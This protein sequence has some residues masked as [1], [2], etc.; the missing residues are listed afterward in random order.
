MKHKP[1]SREEIG[2]IDSGNAEGAGSRL[3][4][5]L[6]EKGTLTEED[7]RRIVQSQREKGL[8]FGEAAVSLGLLTRDDLQRALSEQYSYPYLEVGGSALDRLLVAAHRPFSR[9]A[10]SFRTLRTEL[11]MRWFDDRHKIIAVSMP[12]HGQAASVVAANLAICFAQLGERT[13]LI[14]G[15]FRT[16]RQ[17]DL[18]GLPV[19]PG[20]SGVLTGRSALSDAITTIKPFDNLAVIPAGPI[21]PN[22]QELLGQVS[23]S[24]LLETAPA[25]FNIVVVEMPPILEFADAQRIASLAGGCVIATRRHQTSLA[26]IELCKLQINP[27]GAKIVGTVIIE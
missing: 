4:G 9:Q 19:T 20:L 2:A 27:T 12:R 5:R 3:G 22:P 23:F 15:N 26:D 13:L 16:P 24:Y 6:V 7:V 8:L 17:R 21:P 18:F 11:L 14:D 10:E 1:R 25:G